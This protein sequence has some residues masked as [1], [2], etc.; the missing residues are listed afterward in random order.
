MITSA[1]LSRVAIALLALLLVAHAGGALF[2]RFKQ[3][4][5]IGEIG[6]GLVLGPTLLGT[7]FPDAFGW[8]S[9]GKGTASQAALAALGTS[10]A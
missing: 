2:Q 3:P 1:E 7:T 6:G 10:S 5:V 8:L 4:R 9:T